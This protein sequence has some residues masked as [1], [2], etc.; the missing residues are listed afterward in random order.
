MTGSTQEWLP[1]HPIWFATFLLLSSIVMGQQAGD[2]GE[3]AQSNV[4]SAASQVPTFKSRTDLVL[5][6]VVVRDKKGHHVTGLPKDVFALEENGKQQAISLFDEVQPTGTTILRA[7]QVDRGFSN[8]PFDNA[9]QLRLTVVVLDLL[10]TTLLQRTDA[11][12]QLVKFLSKYLPENQPV[13]LL[14]ITGKGLR[15]LQPITTDSAALIAALKKTPIGP[16]TIANRQDV[17]TKTI[18]QLREIAEAY[19]GIPGRKT[20][21]FAAG[22]LPE[23]ATEQELS[24]SS[25]FADDLR[26]MLKSVIDANISVYPI[27]LLSWAR[28]PTLGGLAQRPSDLFLREFASAT[29]GNRCLE[30]NGLDSCLAEGVEDSRSY[31]LLGFAVQPDDRKP[32]W[33]NLKVKVS[34]PHTDIRARSG[35][36]YGKAHPD[37]AKS[38]RDEEVS[39][40][41]SPLGYS[42]VPMFVKVLTQTSTPG[43]PSLDKK[44]TVTFRVTIPLGSVK[45]DTSK[46]SALDLEVGAIA[47]TSD[48]R[49]AAEFLHPVRGN[50]KPENLQEWAR[51]GIVLLEKLDLSPGSYD[52]RFLTR[53]N[54]A[55]LIGTVVFPLEVK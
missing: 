53:D 6:P 4:P 5:V 51:D 19:S 29:G 46:A 27:G 1:V 7:A 21:I 22:P 54:N 45:V 16:E 10:N 43:A 32:G 14:C 41:A 3:S 55:D 37:D 26:K 49:E 25:I 34:A 44:I 39:A 47:L 48:S 33:R 52:L 9:D 13:S 38:V 17:L 18:N 30:S 23:L 50:P 36:Y 20:M 28:D 12:D 40:L 24:E 35:F 11:K 31:Y 15:L 42:G 8:L 2:T